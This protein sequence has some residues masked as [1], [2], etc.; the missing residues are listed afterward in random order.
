MLLS[1]CDGIEIYG[2]GALQ[3]NKIIKEIYICKYEE[4]EY[5]NVNE[6]DV[7]VELIYDFFM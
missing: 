1:L 7:A 4:K 5:K 3:R 6:E 2:V